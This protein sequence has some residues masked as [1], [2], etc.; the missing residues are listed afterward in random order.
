MGIYEQARHADTPLS[1]F[2]RERLPHADVVVDSWARE[3][4]APEGELPAPGARDSIGW[5]LELCL[6]LDLAATPPRQ[7]E[8]SFLLADRY[9]ALLTAAGYQ[10]RPIAGLPANAV[11]D[12]LLQHWTRAGYPSVLDDA[13]RAVFAMCLDLA[14]LREVMHGWLIREQDVE[15]RRSLFT[16]AIIESADFGTNSSELL[17]ALEHCWNTYLAHGRRRLQERGE[18]VIVAPELA[19]GYGVAD[20]VIGRTLLEVKLAVEPTAEDVVVW[21]RQL[22]GYVLLDRHDTFALDTIAVY[23]GWSGLLLTYPLPTLLSASGH[24]GPAAPARLRGD[25]GQLLADE[26]DGYAAWRERERY[27]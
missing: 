9:E 25:F 4:A 14:S 1:R 21:L 11:T 7:R 3:L 23:C 22:L 13:R 17:T 12:P 8:L 27:R 2:V 10:H 19:S 24:G 26:L 15:R 6:D 20:L 5:A 18:K 16:W